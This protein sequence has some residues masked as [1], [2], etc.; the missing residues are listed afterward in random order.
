LLNALE[1][2]TDAAADGYDEDDDGDGD[3]DAD[4][5]AISASDSDSYAEVD[6]D[7]STADIAERPQDDSHDRNNTQMSEDP[8]S[9]SGSDEDLEPDL[10]DDAMFS[11]GINEKLGELLRLNQEGKKRSKQ[12]MPISHARLLH[13]GGFSDLMGST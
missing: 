6:V 13:H 1:P 3:G 5:D 9:S 7:S 2:N 11:M 4:E 12:G 8:S 10:D